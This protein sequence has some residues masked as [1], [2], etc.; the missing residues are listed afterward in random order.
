MNCR[1]VRKLVSLVAMVGILV[2]AALVPGCMCGY[3]VSAVL[4][5]LDLLANVQT[6]EEALAGDDLTEHQKQRLRY[7][8]GV[9]DYAAEQIGLYVGNSYETF[10]NTHGQPLAYNLS[11]CP[12]DQLEP[13]TWT[14]P[15]VGT[16][17]YLGF[18]DR[19]QAEAFRDAVIDAG[20]DVFFYEVDA[21]STVNIVPDPIYSSMLERDDI[22]LAEVVLHELTHNTVFSG[23]IV[24]NESI[25]TFVQRAAAL[26]FLA[27]TYGDE[28]A[29][30]VD[31][32]RGRHADEDL[33]TEWIDELYDELRA[34]YGSERSREA[35]L[36]EREDIIEQARIRFADDYLPLLFE[37]ENYSGVLSAEI[38][39]AVV[40]AYRRYHSNFDTYQE[41][42]EELDS[43]FPR[44]LSLFA[45]ASQAPRPSAFVQEWLSERP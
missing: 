44:L 42:F 26:R 35:K 7:A 5:E 18:F 14:F 24:F 38:N 41:A 10:F 28:D 15:I 43:S 34:L 16:F 2:C 1:S 31:R 23:D 17:E 6:I 32:A 29:E 37:P 45:E 30:I 12:P 33:F 20:F 4:G 9:R 21:Y 22:D 3:A 25:A 39:N 27:D 13:L 40:L 11:A 19:T 36:T 8:V